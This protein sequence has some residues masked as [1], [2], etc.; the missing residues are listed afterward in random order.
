MFKALYRL[1][2][3][4]SLCA[5]LGYA[6]DPIALYECEDSVNDTSTAQDY[7]LTDNGTISY[8]TTAAVGTKSCSFSSYNFV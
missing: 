4:M 3:S 6:A 8:S 7:N 1:S 2:L 5:M